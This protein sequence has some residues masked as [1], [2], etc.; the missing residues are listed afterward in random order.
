LLGKQRGLDREEIGEKEGRRIWEFPAI[1]GP[2]R[3]GGRGE[4]GAGSGKRLHCKKKS[5][6]GRE[7]ARGHPKDRAGKTAFCSAVKILKK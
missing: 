6:K 3:C 2:G 5:I 1:F 7:K 4:E